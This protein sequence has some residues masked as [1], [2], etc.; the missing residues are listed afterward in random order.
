[1]LDSQNQEV[2][3]KKEKTKLHSYFGENYFG[4]VGH[5]QTLTRQ[6]SRQGCGPKRTDYW[7]PADSDSETRGF[8]TSKGIKKKPIKN[9]KKFKRI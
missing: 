9:N 4:K 8:H 6:G 5:N 1:M 2:E 7:M 3:E